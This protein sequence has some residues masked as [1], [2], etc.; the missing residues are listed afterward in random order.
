[1]K[2]YQTNKPKTIGVE[3]DGTV[4]PLITPKVEQQLRLEDMMEAA[5]QKGR[6]SVKGLVEFMESLG[7]PREIAVKL[8]ESELWEILRGIGESKKKSQAQD[9]DSP[10]LNVSTA[11]QPTSGSGSPAS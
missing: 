9:T 8:E 2:K 10:S 5:D 4:Y 1:M 7:L 3:I 11:G 6:Y